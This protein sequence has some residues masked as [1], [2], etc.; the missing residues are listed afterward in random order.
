MITNAHPVTNYRADLFPLLALSEGF[1][2]IGRLGLPYFD[3]RGSRV[4]SCNRTFE[5]IVR[6]FGLQGG[7]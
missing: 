7:R 2:E 3:E 1:G 4:R 6:A 5:L